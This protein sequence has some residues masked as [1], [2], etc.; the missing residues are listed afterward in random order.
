M[1]AVRI[2][3]PDWPQPRLEEITPDFVLRQARRDALPENT[4]YADTG[5]DLHP[6]CL[7]CPM[8]RCRYDEPGGAR[9]L[10]SAERDRAIV[11]LQREGEPIDAIATRFG[12]SRRTIFRV[13]AR[14]KQ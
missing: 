5:C 3:A 7:T 1:V 6:N 12:V 13:L 11:A 8:V 14:A 10:L 2:A 9:G 4:H